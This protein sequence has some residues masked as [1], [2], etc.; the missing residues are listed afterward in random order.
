LEL[1]IHARFET[2][3]R[4]IGEG[5]FSAL[6]NLTWM[7]GESHTNET[8]MSAL[9]KERWLPVPCIAAVVV[10]LIAKNWYSYVFKRE[11]G[12][13]IVE[14]RHLEIEAEKEVVPGDTLRVRSEI[15]SGEDDMVVIEHHAFNQR[16]EHVAVVRQRLR[17]EPTSSA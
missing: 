15:V 7:T 1:P 12:I 6:C 2:Q 17:V 5:D 14:S 10:G 11:L 13:R 3:G 4:T 8:A 9:G 16:D